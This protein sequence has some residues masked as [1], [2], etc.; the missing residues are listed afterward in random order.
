MAE[1]NQDGFFRRIFQE[2]PAAILVVTLDFQITDANLAAQRMF[3]RG[4]RDLR[5]SALR[6]FVAHS[7]QVAFKGIRTDI[8]DQNGCAARPLLLRLPDETECE[9]SLTAAVFRDDGGD[10]QFILMTLLEGGKSISEDML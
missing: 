2:S 10:S 4:L 1:E 5:D 7:D 3:K 9:V 6:Q 8:E